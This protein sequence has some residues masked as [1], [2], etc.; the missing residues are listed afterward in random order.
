MLFKDEYLD[1]RKQRA[2]ARKSTKYINV[3]ILINNMRVHLVRQSRLKRR[4]RYSRLTENTVD[5]H[6]RSLVQK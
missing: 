3:Q 4:T 1:Y 2:R 5:F 6:T